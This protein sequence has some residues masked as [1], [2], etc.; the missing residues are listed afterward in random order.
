[1]AEGNKRVAESLKRGRETFEA[2]DFTARPRGLP[3]GRS[4]L[5]ES[6]ATAR[7]YLDRIEQELARPSS[8]LDLSH[9]APQ[10]DILAEEMADA[11]EPEP[12]T[13]AGAAPPKAKPK[14]APRRR[15]ARWTAAFLIALGGA[16]LLA[17]AVGGY[18][19]LRPGRR[20]GAP[21][22]ARR[23]RAVARARDRRSSATASS[24]RRS[25]SSSRSRPSTPTTRAPR[26][27]WRR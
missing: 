3:R 1:M 22:R 12:P 13:S 16:L 26:S 5:D 23:R 18:F 10:S 14:P 19:L 9:K 24:P 6:D 15:G 25:R 27:C 7:S 2:G 21:R 11:A 4:P 20:Q 8:G 17:V